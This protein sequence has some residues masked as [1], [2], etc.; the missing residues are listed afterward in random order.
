MS[1]YGGGDLHWV[2]VTAGGGASARTGKY[3]C[4]PAQTV[5]AGWSPVLVRPRPFK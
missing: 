2:D 5:T 4:D 1:V 3:R